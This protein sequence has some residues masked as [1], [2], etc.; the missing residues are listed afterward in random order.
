MSAPAPARPHTDEYA[1]AFEKYVS[2]VPDADLLETLERQ[3]AE[4]LALLRGLTEERGA[5]RYEPGKWSV[6][7]RVGHL[8]DTERLFAYRVLAISRGDAQPLPGMEQDEWMAAVD[9]DARTLADLADEFEAVRAA[10]L[11]LLRHLSPEAWARRGTA[12]GNEVTVRALAYIIA[13]HEAH[14]VRVLRERY[15]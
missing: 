8:N 2:L 10:T 12:N 14:H 1:P 3:G 9:F 5:H 11:H 13:G 4:T 6:K 15:L 7:Q